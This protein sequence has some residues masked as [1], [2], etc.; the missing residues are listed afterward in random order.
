MNYLWGLAAS[1]ATAFVAVH[2]PAQDRAL[3]G[4]RIAAGAGPGGSAMAC[5]ACHGAFGLGET[6]V[7]VPRLAGLDAHYLVKQL[8]DYASGTRPS[9]IMKP[10]AEALDAGQR[11]AVAG[12]YADKPVR[13]DVAA[14]PTGRPRDTHLLQL[15]A[16]LWSRGSAEHRVQ[17]CLT[18]H[19]NRRDA[20]GVSLYP[21]I[22]GQPERYVAE[23]LRQFRDGRRRNDVAGAMRAVAAR[24]GDREIEALAAYIASLPP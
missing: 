11:A 6:G 3:E 23:Q 7:G 19:V 21:P 1:V 18:C 13:L 9:A 5:V 4:E 8:D 17:A 10:I 16:A 12:Y 24:L 20:A 22:A 15:G 14:R 2:S